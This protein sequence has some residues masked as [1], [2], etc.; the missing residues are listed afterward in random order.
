[1]TFII[2]FL[3]M[4]WLG[5]FLAGKLGRN[6]ALWFLIVGLTGGFGLIVMALIHLADMGRNVKF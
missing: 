4:G 6:Q 1:M 5:A 2:I 3:L